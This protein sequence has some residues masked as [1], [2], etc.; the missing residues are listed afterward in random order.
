[1]CQTAELGQRSKIANAFGLGCV[2]V[3]VMHSTAIRA[4]PM[5]ETAASSPSD[6]AAGSFPTLFSLYFRYSN[7]M[8]G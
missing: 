6:T 8:Y 2:V 5:R 1:M 7:C 4:M 3:F